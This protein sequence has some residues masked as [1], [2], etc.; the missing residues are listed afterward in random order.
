MLSLFAL[1]AMAVDNSTATGITST[2]TI[3]FTAF[4]V[5]AISIII[6]AAFLLVNLLSGGAGVDAVLVVLLSTIG[7]GIVLFVGY[8]VIAQVA[9][10]LIAA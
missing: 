10:G 5:I 8:V 6:F 9:A 4:A 1:P 7:L 3:V 2:Q